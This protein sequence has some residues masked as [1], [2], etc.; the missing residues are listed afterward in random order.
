[1]RR[2][3]KFLAILA[4]VAVIFISPAAQASTFKSSTDC[5]IL[6]MTILD[7]ISIMGY[8]FS[9]FELGFWFGSYRKKK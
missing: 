7:F 9:V 6:P 8:T 4:A 1:M 2:M 5:E 3:K